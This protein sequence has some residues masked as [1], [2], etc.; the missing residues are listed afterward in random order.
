MKNKR[1]KEKPDPL[2]DIAFLK[3]LKGLAPSGK[4][5]IEE[6][7]LST[8]GKTVKLTADSRKEIDKR[9]KALEKEKEG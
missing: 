2:K 3:A 7:T 6:I 8:R 9:I 5:G 1:K 4:D